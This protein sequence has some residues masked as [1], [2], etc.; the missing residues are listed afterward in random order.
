MEG[1]EEF[2]SDRLHVVVHDEYQVSISV[3]PP[4][5]AEIVQ[6]AVPLNE[7]ELA[8]ETV[9]TGGPMRQMAVDMA[10]QRVVR[11]LDAASSNE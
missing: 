1:T 2:Q 10:A 8:L 6:V 11:L 4:R 7:L 5:L 9:N 3:N